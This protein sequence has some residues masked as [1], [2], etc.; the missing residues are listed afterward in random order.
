MNNELPVVFFLRHIINGYGQKYKLIK[1]KKLITSIVTVR[2][3]LHVRT[4]LI[5]LS[6][7][8]IFVEKNNIHCK[9][10]VHVAFLHK[11]C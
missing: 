1:K 8:P 5:T 7:T 6:L 10:Q 2:S 11:Y 3:L 9:F 4:N